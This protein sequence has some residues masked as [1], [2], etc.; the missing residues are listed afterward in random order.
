MKEFLEGLAAL[1]NVKAEDVADLFV[2]EG[3]E[4]KL[5]DGLNEL[6]VVKDWVKTRVNDT[7]KAGHRKGAAGME[8]VIKSKGFDS[9]L[10]GAELLNAY[11]DTLTVEPSEKGSEWENKYRS[12][13]ASH[14][15]ALEQLEAK[16]AE[17]AAK[18]K[19]GF[20]RETK[21]RFSSDARKF[22]GDR[23]A[24]NEDHFNEIIARYDPQRIRYENE[25]PFLLDEKGDY[26]V[27]DLHVRIRLDEDIKRRGKLIGGF[28]EVDPSK[29]SPPPPS[30]QGGNGTKTVTLPG[31]MTDREFMN[32]YN[33]E[34]N[35]S[36]R[37]A[38]MEARTKQIE[39]TE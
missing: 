36:K 24:G 6:D 31:G 26:A 11:L 27:D 28:H 32:L 21:A 34:N 1:L 22:L 13:E 5:K 23:W 17:I 7:Y 38:M 8:S 16:D 19:E 37:K 35:P 18:E 9:D 39:E 10:Q 14:K 15:K 4:T 20:T 12:L 29:G 30:G 33:S 3:E 2:T 25:I